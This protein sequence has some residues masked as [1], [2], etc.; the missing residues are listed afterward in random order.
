MS[1]PL[2]YITGAFGALGAL[3][4]VTPLLPLALGAAGATSLTAILYRDI[5]LIP[6]TLVMIGLAFYLW[7]RSNSE[8]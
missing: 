2:A 6:F 7:R 5:V 3:C 4:C 8:N 1:R